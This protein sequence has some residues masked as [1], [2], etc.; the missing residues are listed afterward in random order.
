S[1]ARLRERLFSSQRFWG[2]VLLLMV[3]IFSRQSVFFFLTCLLLGAEAVSLYWNHR[4]LDA[5]DYRRLLSHRRAMWG[6]TVTVTVEV[7]NK[8]WLPLPWLRVD[9][10]VPA[11]AVRDSATF[12][13]Y[14]PH[15]GLLRTYLSVL[16]FQRVAS[17]HSFVCLDRG[18]YVFG[19][20]EL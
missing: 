14:K 5:L 17:S 10:E 1:A 7:E 2:A 6:D 20:S 12:T 18:E 13:F 9:D 15:R 3:A 11:A 16:W 8:K 19:P 4:A